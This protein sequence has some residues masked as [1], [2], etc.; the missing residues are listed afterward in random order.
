MKNY[1]LEC[2][3]VKNRTKL[4]YGHIFYDVFG[5]V[6]DEANSLHY[7]RVGSIKNNQ[8]GWIFYPRF[9]IRSIDTYTINEIAKKMI[10]LEN[11]ESD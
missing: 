7:M 9:L 2:K 8:K 5:V 6:H 1:N 10:Q 4:Y 11:E 3:I